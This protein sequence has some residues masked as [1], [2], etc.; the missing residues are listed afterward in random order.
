MVALTIIRV[1]PLNILEL[2]PIH[3]GWRI[4]RD[5]STWADWV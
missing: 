1:N 4:V 2:E 3:R 5:D